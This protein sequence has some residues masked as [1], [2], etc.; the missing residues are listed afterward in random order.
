MD[1][2]ELSTILFGQFSPEERSVPDSVTYPGRNAS[3]MAAINGAWQEIHTKCPDFMENEEFGVILH[4]PTPVTIAV[5]AD[6][7]QAT[8]SEF[9]AWM[10]G[11][12]IVISG[13]NI[14]NRIKSA[15]GASSYASVTLNPDGA[16]NSITLTAVVPGSAGNSITGE[17]AVSV[18]DTD[19]TIGVTG[20][21]ILATSGDKNR[22]NVT[23][24]LTP[25]VAG[26]LYYAGEVEGK[27]HWTSNGLAT[28]VNLA[29]GTPSQSLGY[30]FGGWIFSSVLA[31]GN[32]EFIAG[33]ISVAA[34][35]DGL[36]FATTLGT[37]AITVTADAA[38]AQQVIDA[39]NAD[40][41]ASELVTASASGTV[42]GA[43]DTAAATLSG[44]SGGL[45]L[46][47][48]YG[49]TTGS[50]SATVFHTSI[51]LPSAV[52]KVVKPVRVDNLEIIPV[53]NPEGFSATTYGDFGNQFRRGNLVQQNIRVN[54]TKGK[55][56]GYKVKSH[57]VSG[58]AT[59]TKRMRI[60][61]APANSGTLTYRAEMNPPFV[62]DLA[63]TTL[64]P[65]EN[66]FIESILLPI[67]LFRLTTSPFFRNQS[68][69]S[70]IE[71]G[72]ARAL[73]DL[74]ALTAQDNGEKRMRPI[75]G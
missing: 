27:P 33:I 9:A 24:S 10:E 45:T 29:N 65:F 50:V 71:K 20:T 73:A 64:F 1:P 2:S 47:Y 54:D 51:P 13:H 52:M 16:D 11:C 58:T 12:E 53:S 70:A 17:I 72:Y 22:M 28:A 19:L 36:S 34:F 75:Y 69:L 23:G 44:G 63:A 68:G 4:E 3:V 18:N 30:A 6:S 56:C 41:E 61:P 46:L 37:G 67:A 43:V 31:N 42:T 55:V 49:G 74:D 62:T 40:A 14:D 25:D 66:Q 26:W 7:K 39:V 38:T 59:P 15:S 48:P 60:V 32:P 57:Y 5:V 8:I 35:P 21:A